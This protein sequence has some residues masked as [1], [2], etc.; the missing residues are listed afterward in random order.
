MELDSRGGKFKAF[1]AE[2]AK[3]RVWMDEISAGDEKG[4]RQSAEV[5]VVHTSLP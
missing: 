1:D 4:V 2:R 5:G 3:P